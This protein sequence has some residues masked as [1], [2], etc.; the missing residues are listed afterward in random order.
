MNAFHKIYKVKIPNV[1]WCFQ[2]CTSRKKAEDELKEFCDKKG[3]SMK[4]TRKGHFEIGDF[5]FQYAE[6]EIIIVK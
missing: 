5:P 3:L 1:N 2:Y 4:E 6:I